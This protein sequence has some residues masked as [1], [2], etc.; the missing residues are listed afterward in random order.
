MRG[1]FIVFDGA[2]GTGTTTH[3]LLLYKFLKKK[4][5]KVLLTKEPFPHQSEKL[6]RKSLLQKN[7]DNLYLQLLFTANRAMHLSTKIIPSLQRG[8]TVI[9]DRYFF[10]TLVFGQIAGIDKKFLIKIN[11]KFIRPDITFF[12]SCD[13][14]LAFSRIKDRGKKRDNFEQIDTIK[15]AN[16]IYKEM[17]KEF[18]AI[19][20][21]TDDKLKIVANEIWK[22]IKEGF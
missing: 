15:K 21:N 19:Q 10:S 6:I 4:R 16:E 9:C 2:D 12:L 7:V 17:S 1:T 18:N 22:K 5:N 3:S 13:E 14:K 20:I 8:E 11:E